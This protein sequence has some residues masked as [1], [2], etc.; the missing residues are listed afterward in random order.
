M[1][2]LKNNTLYLEK[3]NYKIN[4]LNGDSFSFSYTL[5]NENIRDLYKDNLTPYTSHKALFNEIDDVK[6]YTQELDDG[7]NINIELLSNRYS[8]WGVNLPFN[9]MGK[10]NGNGYTNQ[11]L[12]N[13]PYKDENNIYKYVYLT[14]PNGNNLLI[15]LDKDS[16][17]WKMDYSP[18]CG[19]HFFLNLKILSQFDKEYEK[20]KN[21][22]KL[23]FFIYE[24]KDFNEAILKVSNHFNR[25]VLTYDIS[26][27]KLNDKININIIG[28]CDYISDGINKYDVKNKDS[29]IY[30]IQKEGITRL[31]PYVN[32]ENGLETTIYGYKNIEDLY[33]KSIYAISFDD[34]NVTDR[35]L[36]EHQCYV[37]ASLRYM[38]KYGKDK[39][40]EEI[41]KKALS[42]IMETDINKAVERVTVLDTA[43][44]NYGVPSY[45][46]YHSKR[47]QEQFFGVTIFLDAYKYFKDEK[48]LKYATGSMNT[49]IDLYQEEDGGFYT[50]MPWNRNKD[51]YSTVTCLILPLIDLTLF[52]KDKDE[53]LYNKYLESTKKL[54]KHVYDRGLNFPTETV[55]GSEHEDEMED[56]SISCTAL[57][58]LYYSY[59]IE[60][61]EEYIKKA[62]EI[63]DLHENWVVHTPLVNAYRSSLR[64]WE[65][66][67]EGD[68]DGPALCLGH[69]WTIWRAEADYFMYKLSNG[70]KYLINS[71]NSFNT[72]FAKIEE[73]GSSYSCFF[74]DYITGGGR[75]DNNSVIYKIEKP[76][77]N[78]KDSGLSRYVWIRA[79][80]TILNELK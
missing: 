43:D 16:S 22:K 62:K 40:T 55:V 6:L 51:D 66:Y 33:K 27:G 58:L 29:F 70:K 8:E 20:D 19:G 44:N 30:E 5:K 3:N 77:P 15:I 52:M 2:S 75:A 46:V 1:I 45:H 68:C 64:W 72:N 24:V 4:L 67:W 80:E 57:T 10:V 28:K 36:C 76:I 50:Q 25:P 17:G 59:K 74:L 31:V 71:I 11:Y 39:K 26:G 7:I 35:N 34:I 38:L 12:F 65:T 14:N 32:E 42:I 48:Y 56:G 47:I 49:L 69:A 78:Q 18:Y 9:F 53:S 73:D 60:R 79:F 54:A 37:S 23:S 41:V 61:N 13:S 21:N 63:L